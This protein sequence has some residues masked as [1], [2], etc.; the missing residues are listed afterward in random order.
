MQELEPSVGGLY[1]RGDVI[2][3]FYSIMSVDW[4]RQGLRS[5]FEDLRFKNLFSSYTL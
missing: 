1:A 3:G 4:I 5:S 2:V